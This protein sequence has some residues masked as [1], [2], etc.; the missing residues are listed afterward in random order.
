MKKIMA[1]LCFA[2]FAMPV[3]AAAQQ[4]ERTKAC[5]S[6]ATKK[7]LKGDK[8]KAY[9]KACVAGKTKKKPDT[10]ATT[11]KKPGAATASKKKDARPTTTAARAQA[12]TAPAQPSAAAT[13]TPAANPP[14]AQSMTSVDEKKRFRCDEIAR[15]SNVSPAR[16]KEFMDKCMAG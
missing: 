8:H 12:P 4:Q 9:V 13:A 3:V 6:A 11:K 2:L 14:A 16:N 7:A 10:A 15:Q 1:V 5:N